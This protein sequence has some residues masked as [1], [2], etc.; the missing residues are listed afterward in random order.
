LK[1]ISRPA[2]TVKEVEPD[3]AVLLAT[4]STAITLIILPGYARALLT[5]NVGSQETFKTTSRNHVPKS[6]GFEHFY[7]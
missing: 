6:T 4:T 2:I 7:W 5:K 1:K 3:D